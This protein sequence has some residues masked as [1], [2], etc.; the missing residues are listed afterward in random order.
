MGE[1]DIVLQEKPLLAIFDALDESVSPALR[2]LDY[3]ALMLVFRSIHK[4]ELL[5]MKCR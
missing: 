1:D 2:Q 5:L 3:V 4:S